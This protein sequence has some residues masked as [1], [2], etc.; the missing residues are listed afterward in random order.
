VRAAAVDETVIDHEL[1]AHPPQAAAEQTRAGHD[2]CSLNQSKTE[3]IDQ[4]VYSH[5][6]LAS[7]ASAS[8]GRHKKEQ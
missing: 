1:I 2:T 8:A 7:A 4:T 6:N 5:L 3:F